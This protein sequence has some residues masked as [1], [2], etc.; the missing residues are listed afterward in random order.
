M[1]PGIGGNSPEQALALLSDMTTDVTA[2]GL[3]EYQRRIEKAQQYMQQ[4]DIAAVYLNAGT[5]MT[6]FTGT[7][8]YASERL[9]GAILPATGQLQYIAPV[10]EIPTLKDYMQ[11]DGPVHGWHEHENPYA[12][13][14]EVLKTENLTAPAKIAIDESTAFFIVDGINQL[15]PG[16]TLINGKEV[17]AHCRM[18]KSD[19]E[20]AL[21]QRAMD[22]TLEVHKAAASI[23]KPGITTTEVETF[24]NQAHQK[25][26]A[27][28]SYFC[29]VLFGEAT[30][31]PH[32]VK[33]PQTLQQGRYG[34]N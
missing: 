1:A 8:W 4:N 14:L 30:A 27:T 7:K 12:L 23:L 22:M 16:F 15:N 5:N 26:G 25:V 21:M 9:V 13:L 19:S 34:I 24:I 2:I 10:F 29:I 28:G 31:Y 20:I 33:D 6:Y 11:V 32:G 3:D 17:T 18:H